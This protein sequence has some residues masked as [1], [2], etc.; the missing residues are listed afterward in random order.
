MDGESFNPADNFSLTKSGIF[1]KLLTRL[2]LAGTSNRN[3]ATR[4]LAIC[5]TVWVPL[6][7]LS[8]FQGL[9]F[10]SKVE[11]SFIKD[12]ANHVRFLLVIPILVFAERSVDSRLR[13]LSNFFFTAGIL[14]EVDAPQYYKIKQ[15]II[16]LSEPLL[17][18]LVIILIIIVNLII[19]WFNRPHESSYWLVA[20]GTNQDVSWAGLWYL[21]ISMPV[22]Q[23]LCIRWI[24][25]WILWF[26]YFKKISDLPLK[27]NP[28]HSDRGGGLGFLGVPP[29]PFLQI[30]FALSIL[31]SAAIADKIFFFQGR[32]QQ[33]YALLGGFAVIAI[34]LNVLPLL[35]FTRQLFIQR[36]RGIF[37]YSA[38]IQEHHRE[39]DQ[40]WIY[41]KNPE[42]ILGTSDPSSMIDINSSFESVMHMRIIPFDLRIMLSSLL[43]VILPMVILMFFEYKWYDLLKLILKM[44]F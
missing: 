20:P 1:Y 27:L 18:D 7:I 14:N 3:Y 43:A 44:L 33:Y 29:G 37:H 28:A 9:A 16:R 8:A 34:V 6:L 41:K 12:F 36:R 30:T 31:F 39:F 35:V 11:I 21:F 26:I 42:P 32:L 25:R 23:Y 15:F 13:E 24:W 22:F 4:L 10:G 19:R 2:N 5:G 40:K 17:A 38:L